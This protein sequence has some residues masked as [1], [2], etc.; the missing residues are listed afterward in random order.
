MAHAGAAH[1]YHRLAYC[2]YW[3]SMWKDIQ[4]FCHSC[5][6]CQKIKPDLQGKKGLLWPHRIPTLPWDMVSLDLI[7]G[8][9]QL[10]GY[11]AILV[12]VDKLSKYALYT[13][14]T[15]TLSQSRFAMLFLE[16][17]VQWFGLP[18]EMIAN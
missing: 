7:T 8:L 5:D 17:I 18:L 12:I 9:P 4:Q 14:T 3:P 6:I 13:P 11:D 1:L 15:S 16:H 2:Y 10:Q